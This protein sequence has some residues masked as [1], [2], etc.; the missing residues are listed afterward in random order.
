MNKNYFKPLLEAEYEA[1]AIVN[2][3]DLPDTTNNDWTTQ[4]NKAKTPEE[5]VEVI[6]AYFKYLFG[7]EIDFDDEILPIVNTLM[8]EI[9]DN[10]LNRANLPQID[11]IYN[12]HKF[13]NKFDLTNDQYA[14]L[15][16]LF[17]DYALAKFL[18]AKT[19]QARDELGGNENNI[20]F[21]PSFY[22]F[23]EADMKYILSVWY[24][25]AD[26]SKTK[27]IKKG[28]KAIE[29]NGN[30]I[31]LENISKEDSKL[32]RDAIIFNDNTKIIDSKSAIANKLEALFDDEIDSMTK[33][34]KFDYFTRLL[35]NNNYDVTEQNDI[36]III[37]ALLEFFQ[38]ENTNNENFN[39]VIG[40]VY[41]TLDEYNKVIE[42]EQNK[43][44]IEFL[45]KLFKDYPEFI[46]TSSYMEFITK[47]ARNKFKKERVR[48]NNKSNTTVSNTKNTVKSPKVASSVIDK[49][50]N[51]FWQV[52]YN[53]Q[54]KNNPKFWAY[55]QEA[56]AKRY[57]LDT[58]DP[59]WYNLHVA[60]NLPTGNNYNKELFNTYITFLK[61]K[62]GFF[63]EFTSKFS[64]KAI[65]D[66]IDMLYQKGR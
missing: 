46:D 4:I 44:D 18:T 45:T 13:N 17:A 38:V 53:K 48:N 8:V 40:E 28:K 65:K 16:N 3:S 20:I 64:V 39:K 43:K 7:D 19:L 58:K 42:N 21:N 59:E 37:A 9:R 51:S 6:R 50:I 29:I 32:I 15:H 61:N 22:T 63:R 54:H 2:F 55:L 14:K 31:S 11:F 60:N 34:N 27:N 1:D 66:L 12:Y 30:I 25:L 5:E 26:L 41:K 49:F 10:G 36:D 62:E 57:K 24:E 47:L 33:I 56:L 52:E 35:L 23:S